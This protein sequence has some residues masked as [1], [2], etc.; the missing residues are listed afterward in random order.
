[1]ADPYTY[2]GAGTGFLSEDKRKALLNLPEDKYQELL[3]GIDAGIASGAMTPETKAL[4]QSYR[5]FGAAGPTAGPPPLP[6]REGH[7]T[8]YAR[9]EVIAEGH[10]GAVQ[11]PPLSAMIAQ[12]GP[13]V[14]VEPVP[15]A[16]AAIPPMGPAMK[17]ITPAIP[18]RGIADM[19]PPDMRTAPLPAEEPGLMDKFGSWLG[20]GDNRA[21]LRRFGLELMA[22]KSSSPQEFVRTL[23]EA[24]I[25]TTQA[26]SALKTAEAQREAMKPALERETEYLDTLSKKAMA[27]DDPA[28]KQK[29]ILAAKKYLGATGGKGGGEFKLTDAIVQA[30]WGMG[31]E[32]TKDKLVK[33]LGLQLSKG[34]AE[35]GAPEAPNKPK[36]FKELQAEFGG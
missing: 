31:D 8:R 11:M 7:V 27:S 2:A 4:V 10:P 16:Q 14:D 23:G 30:T 26:M 24:G 5:E 13:P 36:S 20:E 22:R 34:L 29:F 33:L 32:E 18:S 12:G 21:A 19:P 1:M 6:Y 35:A 28:D 17:P 15:P 3:K 25:S 9:P